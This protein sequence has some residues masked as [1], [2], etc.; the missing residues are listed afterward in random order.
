MCSKLGQD[1]LTAR[2][3]E[4]NVGTS[5]KQTKLCQNIKDHLNS[6]WYR[7]NHDFPDIH[8]RTLRYVYF[9]YYVQYFSTNGKQTIKFLDKDLEFLASTGDAQG[10]DFYDV[11]DVVVNYQCA[12]SLQFT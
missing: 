7:Y 5:K 6:L 3:R 9:F 2:E 1:I 8:T 4:V 11:K 12:G 10:M